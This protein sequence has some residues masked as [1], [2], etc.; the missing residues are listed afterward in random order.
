MYSLSDGQYF[1]VYHTRDATGGTHFR[2]SVAFD[3]L[4]FDDS[5][6]PPSIRK[7]TQTRRDGGGETE[8]SRNVAPQASASASIQTPIQYWIESLHDGRIDANPLPPDYWSSYAAEQSP[9]S[10]TLTYTWPDDG[11]VTL[12]GASIAFFADQPAGSNI[13][14]PPPASV[15]DIELASS[16]KPL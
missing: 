16:L 11:V 4:E 10:V 7:V 13:G 1:L 9:Q 2:R 6:S 3:A 5:T 14:V 12:N 15:S 8:P